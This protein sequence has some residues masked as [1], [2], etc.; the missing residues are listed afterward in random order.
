MSLYDPI[1][2]AATSWFPAN[3]EAALLV[4]SLLACRD[5]VRMLDG[6][7]QEPLA[8]RHG[9]VLLATPAI[10]LVDNVL[11]LRGALGARD[12]SAWPQNDR[13]NL[14]AWGR[15]LSRYMQ[16][17]LYRLRS[18]LSAHHDAEKLGSGSVDVGRTA[19]EALEA[20]PQ[21]LCVLILLLNHRG[22][23]MW[24]RRPEDQP[25]VLQLFGTNAFAAP[26]VRVESGKV[27]ELL[28]LTLVRDPQDE[29]RGAALAAMA[30][31]N[32][33]AKR[34]NLAKVIVTDV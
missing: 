11:K 23:F 10:S 4:A 7:Q 19:P 2:D 13:E 6:L 32:R 3:R 26:T 17:P 25:D 9:L 30:A 5:V 18:T 34:A 16:G 24:S 33:V 22:V 21:A 20:I 1:H 27:V 8:D 12:K 14:R 28:K 15:S 31:Y 29:A